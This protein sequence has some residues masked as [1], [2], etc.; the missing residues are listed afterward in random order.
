MSR[1]FVSVLAALGFLALVV[2]S[3]IVGLRRA[4]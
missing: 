4:T 2:S 1:G 3:L